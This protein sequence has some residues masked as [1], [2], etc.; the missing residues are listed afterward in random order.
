MSVRI[1]AG[2]ATVLLVFAGALALS[3]RSTGGHQR[4]VPTASERTVLVAE[5]GA[6]LPASPFYTRRDCLSNPT[7][8]VNGAG[9]IVLTYAV[10][11]GTP[12]TS[13]AAT[14]LSDEN[15]EPDRFG[16][17]HCLNKLRL[18]S[19]RTI[20]VRHDHNM[21]NDPCLGPGERVAVR[22]LV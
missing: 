11:G 16:V 3:L 7:T 22:P 4:P 10:A 13:L 20:T 12:R 6:R 2:S 8:C 18:G 1:A 17:S 21:G 5:G 15:C 9:G 19:G 14:V